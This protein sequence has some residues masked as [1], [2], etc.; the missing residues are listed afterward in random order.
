MADDCKYHVDHESRIKNLEIA[1]AKYQDT[2]VNPG[3]WLGI[4]SFLGICLSSLG[5]V[6]GQIFSA[7]FK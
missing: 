6:L 1:E 7:Y 5:N 3:L 4:F 2:R